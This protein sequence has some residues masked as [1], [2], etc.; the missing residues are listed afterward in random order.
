M[1]LEQLQMHVCTHVWLRATQLIVKKITDSYVHAISFLND[2]YSLACISL[3]VQIPDASSVTLTQCQTKHT[4]NSD[5]RPE[6]SQWFSPTAQSPLSV[7]SLMEG[8]LLSVTVATVTRHGVS[9]VTCRQEG[10]RRKSVCLVKLEPHFTRKWKQWASLRKIPV[11]TVKVI[12]YHLCRCSTTW[13]FFEFKHDDG[14]QGVK[15]CKKCF[16]VVT[17]LRG[18]ATNLYNNLQRDL[19]SQYELAVKDKGT[20]SKKSH[21]PDERL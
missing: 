20:A 7:L 9:S 21:L 3:S 11:A 1:W 18:N 4:I 2:S 10:R 8:A 6:I 19:K 14:T 17:A 15:I 5:I 16:G 13:N 12:L